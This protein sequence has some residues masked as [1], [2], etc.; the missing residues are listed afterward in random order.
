MAEDRQHS[1]GAVTGRNLRKQ[2]LSRSDIHP[3]NMNRGLRWLV[4]LCPFFAN[5]CE[6]EGLGNLVPKLLPELSVTKIQLDS[7]NKNKCYHMPL[8]FPGR[9][10]RSR[11]RVHSVLSFT[12]G[13]LYC[14]VPC[15]TGVLL[16]YTIPPVC[17][18]LEK[19]PSPVQPPP[20]YRSA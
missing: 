1:Q 12:T 15:C 6:R 9:L 10:Q 7:K 19:L 13:P 3:Q 16:S 18:S 17:V 5:A 14:V 2:L 11:Y 8:D 20:T 4:T